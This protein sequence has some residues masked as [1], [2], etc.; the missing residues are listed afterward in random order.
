MTKREEDI[1]RS[2]AMIG[3]FC[4]RKHKTKEGLC[5]QCLAVYEY[6]AERRRRCPFGDGKPACGRCPH[7][8]YSPAMRAFM[9]KVMIANIPYMLRHP[10]RAIGK[11]LQGGR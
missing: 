1:A 4:R 3:R 6:V 2:Y 5:P 8:C 9:K 11:R 10:V 7:P